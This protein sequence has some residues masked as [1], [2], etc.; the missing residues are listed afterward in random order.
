[1]KKVLFVTTAVAALFTF[2]SCQ[3]EETAVV[4]NQNGDLVFTATIDPGTKTTVNTQTGV[5][6][7]VEGDEIT[8]T[9]AA[10]TSVKYTV[11]SINPNGTAK[12]TKKSGESGSLADGPYTAVY[13]TDPAETQ[14]YSD[15]APSLPMKA[16]SA[17]TDLTFTVSCGLLEL[18]VT[19]AA[20][21]PVKNV[22]RIIVKGKPSDTVKYPGDKKGDCYFILNCSPAQS[23]STAKKFYIAL[24]AGNYTRVAITNSNC[25]GDVITPTGGS[26]NI[27]ANK[28]KPAS[29][30]GKSFAYAVDIKCKKYPKVTINN[31]VWMAENFACD[32]YDTESE[33]YNATGEEGTW[34]KTENYTIPNPRPS[35]P[36]FKDTLKTPYYVDVT[37]KNTWSRR[38]AAQKQQAAL[39]PSFIPKLGYSYNWAA[40]VGVAVD[41]LRDTPFTGNRQGICPNGWHVPSRPELDALKTY[42]EVTDAKGTDMAGHHLKSTSGWYDAANPTKYPQGLD[43]YG[44]NLLPAGFAAGDSISN[45]ASAGHILT[46]TPATSARDLTVTT[47]GDWPWKFYYAYGSYTNKKFVAGDGA[48]KCNGRS[49]RCIKNN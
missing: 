11:S 18:T 33:V 22:N 34:F 20:A 36:T 7:W 40:A 1:M 45:V 12:F 25:L 26:V 44:F 19:A 37:D 35:T 28:I 31:V 47:K 46:S 14:T 3:K 30:S 48:P 23:I 8:I 43:T 38:P 39:T 9:D 49:L 41:L 6:A 16:E 15:T 5:V 17:N 27:T 42:I 10:S 32:K 13:G 4:G 24:P 2:A 21:E 29:I